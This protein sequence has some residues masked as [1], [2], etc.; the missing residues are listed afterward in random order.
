MRI[1]SQIN[2]QGAKSHTV[3]IEFNQSDS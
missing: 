3:F 2:A 1:K